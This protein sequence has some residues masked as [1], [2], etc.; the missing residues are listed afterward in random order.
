MNNVF[1]NVLRRRRLQCPAAVMSFG[2]QPSNNS[3]GQRSTRHWR[4]PLH[5]FACTC[6]SLHETFT[7]YAETCSRKP[8]D[9]GGAVQRKAVLDPGG[10]KKFHLVRNHVRFI[11]CSQ[12]SA[13]SSV[14]HISV[15]LCVAV[16]LLINPASAALRASDKTALQE[17][18]TATGGASWTTKTKWMVGDP[19]SNQWFGVTCTTS[20]TARVL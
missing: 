2:F 19:C 7:A 3:T 10:Y 15:M 17:L 6:G 9:G 8:S 1:I 4:C 14:Q 12:N 5:A 13:N 16:A 18:Y 11:S 20:A